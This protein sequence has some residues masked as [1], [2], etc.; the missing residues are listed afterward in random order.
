MSEGAHRKSSRQI[1]ITIRKDDRYGRGT[2]TDPYDGST[3]EK[4]DAIMDSYV[5]W[6]EASVGVDVAYGNWTHAGFTERA[7]A[8]H[9]AAGAKADP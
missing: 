6:R 5:K 3:P 7:L 9:G 2:K 4:F 8:F 1:W